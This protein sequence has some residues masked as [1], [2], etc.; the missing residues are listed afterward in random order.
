MFPKLW[1]KLQLQLQYD[2]SNHVFFFLDKYSCNQ[3]AKKFHLIHWSTFYRKVKNYIIEFNVSTPSLIITTLHIFKP[4]RSVREKYKKCIVCRSKERK[5][6]FFGT[7]V[8]HWCVSHTGTCSK[9]EVS[10]LQRLTV[11]TCELVSV[12]HSVHQL[13]KLQSYPNYDI[14]KKIKRNPFFIYK[15][16]DRTSNKQKRNTILILSS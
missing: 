11:S 5:K 3:N 12:I 1:S 4:H 7:R 10:M 15:I 2:S 16:I 13:C 14:P 6:N 8:G 9:P